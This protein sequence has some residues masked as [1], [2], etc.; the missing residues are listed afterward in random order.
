[1]SKNLME[2][3]KLRNIDIFSEDFVKFLGEIVDQINE[4]HE[5]LAKL[6]TDKKAS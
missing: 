5:K 6:E 1:M 2:N 3:Q 4:I